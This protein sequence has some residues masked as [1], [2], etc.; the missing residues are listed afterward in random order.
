MTEVAKEESKISLKKIK[1]PISSNKS[2]DGKTV[3]K[4]AAERI[5]RLQVHS[6]CYIG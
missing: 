5:K 4:D 1:K 2:H 6:L 3:L